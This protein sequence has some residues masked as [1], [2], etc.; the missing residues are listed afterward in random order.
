MKLFLALPVY[1]E[2]QALPEFLRDFAREMAAAGYS[3]PDR[4]LL[5][6]FG[7][8]DYT[9]GFRAYRASLLKLARIS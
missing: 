8:R 9:C 2:E 6:S 7:A 1:N 5:M 3:F 4:H